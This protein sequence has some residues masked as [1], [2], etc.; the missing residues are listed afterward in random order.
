MD[1]V[2]WTGSR[3]L[4]ALSY[5]PYFKGKGLLALWTVRLCGPRHPVTMRLPNGG[6][7]WVGDDNAGHL[8]VPYL[9]GKDEHQTT[10]L[11]LKHLRRLRLGES[12]VDIGACVGYYSILAAWDLH[13]RGKGVI[14]AFEPNP[15]ALCYLQC[16]IVLNRLTNIVVIPQGLGA[17]VSRTT[18]Y[19]S[20]NR[21]GFSSL[22]PYLSDLIEPYDISITTLDEFMTQH[23]DSRVGLMKVDIEGGELLAFRGAEKTIARDRPVI[24]YEENESACRAFGYTPADLRN[25]LKGMGYH[26]E[27]VERLSSDSY[28]LIALPGE[29]CP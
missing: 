9:I 14:Y 4:D 29:R 13:R 11:F 17:E 22:Q 3:I 8:L 15:R 5:L 6:R 10:T 7:M 2:A 21:M 18:L 25:F 20:D 19:V 23:P 28:N 16:N 26:V 27:I 12:V 1:W 24:I